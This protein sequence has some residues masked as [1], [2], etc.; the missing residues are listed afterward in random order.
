[1]ESSAKNRPSIRTIFLAVIFI[2][3]FLIAGCTQQP[4]PAQPTQ[5]VTVFSPPTPQPLNSPIG[6]ATSIVAT[7]KAVPLTSA[8]SPQPTPAPLFPDANTA[9][10]RPVIAGLDSPVGLTNAGDGLGRLFVLEQPGR[11]RIIKDGR[12]LPAP[13]LDI[14]DRVGM[15]GNEQGLLGLAFHPDYKN[16][17]FFYVNYTDAQART[18]VARFKVSADPD[19]ADPSSEK[20][21][22]YARW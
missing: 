6:Q 3:V 17:G 2:W 12:L 7:E 18:I 13:F 22:F 4:G 21:L 14:I 15:N 1:M 5:P 8:P 9:A 19:V 20:V 16:N 11:I 10:W